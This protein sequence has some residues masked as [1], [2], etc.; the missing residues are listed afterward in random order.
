MSKSQDHEKVYT[1]S[2]LALASALVSLGFELLKLDRTNSKRV[3]FVFE[4]DNYIQSDVEAFWNSKLRVDPIE[5]SDAQKY[6]KNRIY[7]GE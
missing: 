3:V 2:D 7:A 4:A 6:L 5:Y 1:T